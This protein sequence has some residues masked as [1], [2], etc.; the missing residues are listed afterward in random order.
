MIE[1]IID[2]NQLKSTEVHL[3]KGAYGDKDGIYGA[4][5]GYHNEKGY[6]FCCEYCKGSYGLVGFVKP[7]YITVYRQTRAEAKLGLKGRK[8]KD[9]DEKKMRP[10]MEKAMSAILQAGYNATARRFE[11]QNK[12]ESKSEPAKMQLAHYIKKIKDYFKQS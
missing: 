6:G 4:W 1:E 5:I 3:T 7:D 10:L 2:I 11:N 9:F 8:L 12:Q